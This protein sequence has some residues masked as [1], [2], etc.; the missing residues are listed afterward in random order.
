MFGFRVW[1]EAFRVVCA[2]L[3]DLGGFGGFRGLWGLRISLQVRLQES[4]E[5][6]LS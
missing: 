5:Q 1:G 2:D 6:E 4:L 3:G